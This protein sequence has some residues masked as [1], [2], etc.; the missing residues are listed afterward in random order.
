MINYYVPPKPGTTKLP[1]VDIDK[2]MA[3]IERQANYNRL[4]NNIMSMAAMCWFLLVS[5]ASGLVLYYEFGG[6]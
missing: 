6:Y 3:D 4:M 1:E 5:F 2:L